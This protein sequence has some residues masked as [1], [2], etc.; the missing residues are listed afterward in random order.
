MEIYTRT[1]DL[2]FAQKGNP[3]KIFAKQGDRLSRQLLICQMLNGV[4]FKIAE[5]AKVRFACQKAD[6]TQVLTD[7]GIDIAS[8]GGE[9]ILVLIP[10]S[11]MTASG[12]ALCE[13]IIEFENGEILSSEN[14]IIDVVEN[15]LDGSI[16]SH[17]DYQAFKK[18]L[19]ELRGGVTW[20]IH[21]EFGED[22]VMAIEID[23]ANSLGDYTMQVGDLVIDGEGKMGQIKSLDKERNVAIVRY[24][25]T[26]EAGLPNHSEEDAY[27]VL[28][29]SPNGDLF[30][31]DTGIESLTEKVNEEIIPTVEKNT[32]DIAKHDVTLTY[33]DKRITNLEKGL[34]SDRFVT[35][36]EMA[37]IKDVPV[38]ALPY[39]TVS[40]IGGMTVK[41]GDTLKS[42]KVTEV[43]IVGDNLLPYPYTD[44]TKTVS[45]VTFTDNGDGT[46]VANGTAEKNISFIFSDT[47]NL[48]AGKTYSFNETLRYKDENGT[49]KY[50]AKSLTWQENYS[51][52]TYYKYIS[53]GTTLID[54]TIK[55]MLNKGETVLPYVQYIKRTFELPEAVQ[56]LDGYGLG[57][58]S[59]SNHIRYEDDGYR[60][61][62]RLVAL[63]TISGDGKWYYNETDKRFY[64]FS[65]MNAKRSQGLVL[66][67]RY[68]VEYW[69]AF[70][71]IADSA[72]VYTLD[73][74]NAIL[75]DE[76]LTIVYE[77]DTPEVTDISDLLAE[78]NLIEVEGGGTLAFINEHGLAVPSTITYQV[79]GV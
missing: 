45:G 76:P 44:T 23:E 9:E 17:D 21:A 40:K 28:T 47:L 24:I 35:D 67:N 59:V 64:R 41:D 2:D 32:A 34:P 26:I 50:G 66:S 78:D 63:S 58:G 73:E 49:T 60:T 7:E 62:N 20:A 68:V 19:A 6:K 37:Y 53:S 13:I 43:E 14:F 36:D 3:K 75:N 39:A 38:D 56:A 46:I 33:H 11:V 52:A 27:K 1:I 22:T 15:P 30:W 8:T 4:P 48:V 77:L 10:E 18:E 71:V 69:D 57:T 51:G 42:A 72:G 79:K 25:T 74:F 65:P 29:V 61:Y 55:P 16:E 5:T 12:F 54:V 31:G 70:Y